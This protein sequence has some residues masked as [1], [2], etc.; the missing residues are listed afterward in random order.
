METDGG[1]RVGLSKIPTNQ[2]SRY[3][4]LFSA[5]IAKETKRLK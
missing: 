5:K 2:L 1:A 4:L 3:Y